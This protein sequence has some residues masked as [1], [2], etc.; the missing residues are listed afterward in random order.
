MDQAIYS[1]GVTKKVFHDSLVDENR[2]EGAEGKCFPP[3]FLGWRGDEHLARGLTMWRML[4]GLL[5]LLG[6]QTM[7]IMGLISASRWQSTGGRLLWHV[8]IAVLTAVGLFLVVWGFALAREQ[9]MPLWQPVGA[10]KHLA[11]ALT[12]FSF[13]LLAAAV[14]PAN[15]LKAKLKFPFVLAVK[16]W[17]L[18]H[19]LLNGMLAHVLL[20]GTVLAWSVWAFRYLRRR[21]MKEHAPTAPAAT[22]LTLLALALGLLAWWGFAAVLHGW[23][24]GIKPIAW[25]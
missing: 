8:L 12:A 9:P 17:A 1:N 10:L 5:L 13:V 25:F 20:F 7:R 23:L 22:G 16:S 24:I 2:R 15:H 19:L 3:Y 14:V 21:E 11:F 4:L 18:G 6:I